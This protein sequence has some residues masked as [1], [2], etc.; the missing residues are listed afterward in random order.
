MIQ[1]FNF[2]QKINLLQ[3]NNVNIDNITKVNKFIPCIKVRAYIS[4][5]SPDKIIVNT[6]KLKYS[7]NIKAIEW[8]N[9]IFPIIS[10]KYDKQFCIY[11]AQNNTP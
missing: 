8:N 7:D 11:T 3:N 2:K 9:K 10:I 5:L 1:I 6:R 4:H